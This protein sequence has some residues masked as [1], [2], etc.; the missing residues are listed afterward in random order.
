[1]VAGPGFQG[2]GVS[3]IHHQI[4]I[5]D[6]LVTKRVIPALTGS[7][8]GLKSA[9]VYKALRR[10]DVRLNGRRIQADQA[11]FAGDILDV[12]LPEQANP[13]GQWGDSSEAVSSESKSAYHVVYQDDALLILNKMAG[14]VVH[15]TAKAQE[16]DE[17]TLIDKVRSD[18]K[19]PGLVLCHRL[20]RNTGGLIILART[21][22]IQNVVVELMQLGKIA[23]RYRC[24]VRGEPQAGQKIRTSDG[25]EFYQI[26]AFLEK[27]ARQNEVYIH[28]EKRPGDVPVIT[29]YRILHRFPG[30]GPEGETVCELEVE[31]VTGRTHQIRAHLAHIG[32]PLLGDGKYGRNSYN[33]FFK[34][35]QGPLNRQQLFACQLVFSPDIRA[36][37]LARLAGKAFQVKPA[38]DLDLPGP[39][40][41]LQ[42]F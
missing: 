42:G 23:K 4:V 30:F 35:R 8:P 19:D 25:L 33:R 1:M 2:Q 15:G 28:D 20:D 41:R 21:R 13:E 3:M 36:G 24:L 39:E 32:H 7:V 10:K 37:R 16:D 27:Q 17:G 22:D 40:T 9:Q 11:V 18:Q 12:Y 31:L 14:I 26:E 6:Q 29:R 34:G 38:Y 5:T